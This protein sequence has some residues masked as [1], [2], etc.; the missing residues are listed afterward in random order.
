MIHN[1]INI[2]NRLVGWIVRSFFVV[3]AIF[4]I[5]NIS[6]AFINC[7]PWAREDTRKSCVINQPR[8]PILIGQA[9]EVQ[10]LPIPAPK[11]VVK[12]PQEEIIN[13]RMQSGTLTVSPLVREGPGDQFA[14]VSRIYPGNVVEI[15]EIQEQDWIRLRILEPVLDEWIGWVKGKF[16][17]DV[18]ESDSKEDII[19]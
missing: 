5:L 15:L 18:P 6:R 3:V 19:D 8:R 13:I 2:S 14:V 4:F 16:R 9:E 17:E 12:K 1:T 10:P 11:A 7:G